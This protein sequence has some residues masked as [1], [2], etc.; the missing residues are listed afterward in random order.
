MTNLAEAAD[1]EYEDEQEAEF[2]LPLDSQQEVPV[3]AE[4]ISDGEEETKKHQNKGKPTPKSPA[5]ARPS[6]AN[7]RTN[8]DVDLA[9]VK[10]AERVLG[11]PDNH[12]E[13]EDSLFGRSIAKRMRRLHPRT[14][15][16]LRLQIEQL[17]LNVEF[18]STF[19]APSTS[20]PGMNISSGSDY[21]SVSSQLHHLGSFL[22]GDFVT[23]DGLHQ[24]VLFNF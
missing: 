14:K 18:D 20:M 8:E 17:M 10:V 1:S 4:G 19:P 2:V 9:M 24:G 3:E 16:C 13:D 15:G 5:T 11:S 23:L 7:K 21:K 6:G 12:E 22:I